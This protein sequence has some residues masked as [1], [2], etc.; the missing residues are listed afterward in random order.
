MIII[1]TIIND[2]GQ[3]QPWLTII[4]PVIPVTALNFLQ[5]FEVATNTRIKDLIQN[6][7]K[8]LSLTSAD[9]FSLFVVI[10][11]KVHSSSSKQI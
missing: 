7:S 2:K 8:K 9:G 3:R 11:D 4:L 5:V 1:W 6:I 10:Q